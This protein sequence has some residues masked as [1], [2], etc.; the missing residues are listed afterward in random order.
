MRK[1]I[2]KGSKVLTKDDIN[3]L[4][5]Q[6]EKFTRVDQSIKE[7]HIQSVKKKTM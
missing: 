7:Q 4:F 5:T 2:K 3:L 1:E 6:L